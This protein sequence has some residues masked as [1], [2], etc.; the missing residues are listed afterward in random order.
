[1]KLTA[2]SN[3]TRARETAKRLFKHENA[4]LVAILVILIIATGVI[5]KGATLTRGNIVNIWLQ[6]ATRG[7]A[8]IGNL[9]VI[10]TAGI[11]LSVGGLALMAAILGGSLMTGQTSFPIS[12]IAVM[13]LVGIGI[14]S[15]NGALTAWVP[16]PALVVTLG[17]WQITKGAAFMMCRGITIRYLPESVNFLGGG[18]I[19]GVPVPVIIFV[20]LAVIAYVVLTYTEFGRSVY[21]TGGNP[22]SAWLSG[23]RVSRI[24]FSVF[25]ISGFLA[26]LAG[27][28][29]MARTM[30]AGMQT[31][32]GLE[33]DSIT[34]VFVGGVSLAGGR[35]TVLGAVLGTIIIG[36]V[37]N[38]MIVYGL[39]PAYQDLIKGMIIIAAVAVDYRRRAVGTV[40]I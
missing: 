17:M 22:V 8:A 37:N 23:I 7:I 27:L 38:S 18:D 35:G 5:T 12:A 20:S 28:I 40:T 30:C 2:S 39:D 6:S 24:R 15:I 19:A 36:I 1:M 34:A 31:V 10:L 9:F 14:G 33:L 21:A 16:M 29:L 3:H 32:V 13:L 4:I 26:A 25:V 11:D